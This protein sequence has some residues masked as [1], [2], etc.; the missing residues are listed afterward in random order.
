MAED[1]G[2]RPIRKSPLAMLVDARMAIQGAR[3]RGD[4]RLSHLKKLGNTCSDTVHLVSASGEIED[5][6][7]GRLRELVGD[8]PTSWWWSHIKGIGLINI[9][10]AIGVIEHFGRYYTEAHPDIP[11]YV[12]RPVEDYATLDKEGNVVELKGV[13]VEGIER[14][15]T[16]SAQR[17]YIGHA[18][19]MKRVKG[20]QLPYNS[21][22][23]MVFWRVG[24]SLVRIGPD[25]SYYCFYKDY[26][27]RVTGREEA[28]GRRLIATPKTRYCPACDKDVA[29]KKA[30]YCPDCGGKLDKKEEGEGEFHLGHL[31]RMA[32]RRMQQLFSDHLN[33][34]WRQ[35]LGLPTRDPYPIEKMGHS[36]IITPESMMDKPCGKKDCPICEKYG[37]K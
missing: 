16:P 11:P 25:G 23:K 12:T 18:P 20:Q 21:D 22:A 2:L 28:I 33:I 27:I 36:R 37:L 30:M 10:L 8:H 14:L 17:V 34:V 26:K 19:E 31:D 6:I 35:A 15:I 9:S 24:S 7:D 29:K 13:W 32:R 3:V 5:W 1:K 4:V